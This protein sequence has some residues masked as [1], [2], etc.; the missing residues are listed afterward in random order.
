MA[1]LNIVTEHVKFIKLK[2]AVSKEKYCYS[3]I[4]IITFV[5]DIWSPLVIL[6]K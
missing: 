4:S 3:L 5:A 1:F 2:M 6:K